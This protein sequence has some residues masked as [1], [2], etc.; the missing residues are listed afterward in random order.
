MAGSSI[1][2]RCSNGSWIEAEC[3]YWQCSWR[4]RVLEIS[5]QLAVPELPTAEPQPR[6]TLACRSQQML[7]A[8]T[9]LLSATTKMT[10]NNVRDYQS[11]EASAILLNNHL[12]CI[13]QEPLH[14][15]R[16]ALYNAPTW[17]R[18]PTSNVAIAAMLR[19]L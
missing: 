9:A 16:S 3:A 10:A 17:I 4:I 8:M 12:R 11:E 2:P 7:F 5:Y 14:H 19:D 1:S 6:A 15:T 13:A 18:R